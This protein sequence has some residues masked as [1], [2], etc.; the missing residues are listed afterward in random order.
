MEAI[1]ATQEE[2]LG[3]VYKHAAYMLYSEKRTGE[4]VIE[5][6]KERGLNPEVAEAVVLNLQGEL[7]KA[8][9]A[10]A[11]K[12]MLYG[13]LWLAGGTIATLANIGF[14]FWGAILFGGVQFFKGLINSMD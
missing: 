14:I 9:K 4:D 11:Q 10:Q 6:L 12:D 5:N 1:Q 3:A 7:A 8:K 13:G 2:A